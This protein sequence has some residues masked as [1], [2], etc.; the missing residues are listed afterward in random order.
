MPI[1]FEDLRNKSAGKGFQPTTRTFQ[2]PE[3][4]GDDESPSTQRLI[5]S[6]L[7]KRSPAKG[8]LTH[9]SFNAEDHQKRKT[10]LDKDVHKRSGQLNSAVVAYAQSR[11]AQVLADI[12]I[13]AASIR[14]NAF[15]QMGMGDPGESNPGD[16]GG[17]G[18]A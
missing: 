3:P 15:D 9:F 2:P 16:G 12:D 5:G 17:L 14:A 8:Q 11:L 13:A 4:V 1:D 6:D 18:G 10:E 7:V